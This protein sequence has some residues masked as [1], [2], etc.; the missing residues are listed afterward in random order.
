MTSFTPPIHGNNPHL[1]FGDQ[2]DSA[3]Y[4]QDI[5][6]VNQFDREKL[7][8]IFGVAHEMYEMVARVGSFDLLKG[9]ILANLFYEPST[10]TSSS[11]TSAMERLGGSVIPINNVSYSSVTKGESLPDTVRTLEAYA[12]VIVLRHPE[13]G[14]SAL[15][16]RYARKPVINAGDGVGE[17][18]TQALLDLF[19]IREELGEVDGLTVTMMGD[20]KYGRTVHSLSR[21][22]TLYNVKL[23]YVAPDILQMPPEIMEEIKK[24]GTAQCV[25]NSLEPVSGETDVLYVTRVQKER[26]EDPSKHEE[27]KGSYVVTTETMRQAKDKMIVMHPLPRVWEIDMAVDDDPRA[28][29]FRQMEYGLYIRM[30]LLAMVLGKA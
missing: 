20:L 9:K 30:A 11:F 7:D 14:S 1:P 8:Y 17:H 22:L 21:L 6:S 13:V 12:D 28:A 27:L 4:G 29:Y 19:T 2:Q 25:F 16:A 5:L 23:N 15:A 26:F 18:P 3:F 10:R 24:A